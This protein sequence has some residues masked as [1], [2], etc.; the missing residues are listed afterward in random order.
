MRVSVLRAAVALAVGLLTAGSAQEAT[1]LFMPVNV[2]EN[3]A[4]QV[5]VTD[6]AGGIH[7]AMP[8]VTGGGLYYGYCAP[9]CTG[10]EAVSEVNFETTSNGPG[11]SIALDPQGRPHLLIYDYLQIG[12]AWCSGDCRQ[13]SGWNYGILTSWD[14]PDLMVSGDALAIGPDGRAHFLVHGTQ[15][16]LSSVHETWYYTCAADCHLRGNWQGALIESQQSFQYPSLHVR[17]DGTLVMG[18]IASANPDLG[19]DSPL[20]AY[21]ECAAN[22]LS[23]DSWNGVGLFEAYDVLFS[24]DPGPAVSLGLTADG[25]PRLAGFATSDD[26]SALLVYA[27]CSGNCLADDAWH[28]EVLLNSDERSFGSGLDL[29]LDGADRPSIAYTVSGNILQASCTA[30]C[31]GGETAWDLS[32]VEAGSEIPADDIF[33]YTNCVVGMWFLKDPQIG[34]LPDGRVAALYTAEDISFGGA[35]AVTDP[36]RPACPIGVDMSLGRLSLLQR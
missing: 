11:A 16:F 20:T 30:S 26:G 6:P 32:V 1:R 4:R 12:Y 7:M 10:E 27:A 25:Q 23:A 22:C 5:L 31:E 19:M 18:M 3:V 29:V 28:M 2:A 24:S 15:G 9:G 33:L 13:G 17:S 35:P 34:F 21:M 8:S 14:Q 36:T